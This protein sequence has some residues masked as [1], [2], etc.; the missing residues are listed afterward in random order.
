MAISDFYTV[1]E[2]EEGV[3]LP[4]RDKFGKETD[5]WLLV[6]GVDSQAFQDH[7]LEQDRAALELLK[8]TDEK[9]RRV[10][11]LDLKCKTVAGLVKDWSEGFVEQHKKPTVS[12]VAKFFKLAPQIMDEVD[13]LAGT[14]TAFFTLKSASSSTGSESKQS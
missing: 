1:D 8:E 3:K 4:L 9:K 11:I 6:R 13:K 10:A 7:K 5:E 14:R 2:A 12:N